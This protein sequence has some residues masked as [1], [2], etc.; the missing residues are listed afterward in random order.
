MS[1]GVVYVVDDNA[2]IR[3]VLAA[4]FSSVGLKCLLFEDGPSFFDYFS[5]QPGV[6]L[7]DVRM[8]KMSGIQVQKELME[9]GSNTPIIFFS[10]HSDIGIAVSALKLGAFDF[11]TKPFK[12][13]VVLDAVH[14]ALNFDASQVSHQQKKNEIQEKYGLL[15]SREKE[16]LAAI[17]DAKKTREIAQML[18]ISPNTVEVHRAQI[19]RKMGMRS[20]AQL[21]ATVVKY[22]LI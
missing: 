10:G 20:L 9:R 4:L 15:S 8:P 5:G 2:E 18:S 13:Q 21:V 3:R 6:I 19:M 17:V 7:L 16:I 1:E 11:I 22:D 14:A 12:N